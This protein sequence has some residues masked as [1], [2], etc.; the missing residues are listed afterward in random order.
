MTPCKATLNI[1]GSDARMGDRGFGGSR[2][3]PGKKHPDAG[4][5]SV[6]RCQRPHRIWMRTC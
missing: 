2:D 5:G 4:S 1:Y 3:Y 6:G